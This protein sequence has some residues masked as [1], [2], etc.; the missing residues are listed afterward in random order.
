M[1]CEL[2]HYLE[3]PVAARARSLSARLLLNIKTLSTSSVSLNNTLKNFLKDSIT[4]RLPHTVISN[5]KCKL[6]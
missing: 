6:A 2:L 3:K 4:K 1:K 5:I